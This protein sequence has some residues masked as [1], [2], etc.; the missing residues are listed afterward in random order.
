MKSNDLN[1]WVALYRIE[2]SETGQTLDLIAS[3]DDQGPGDFNSKLT[4][5]LTSDG[6][7][8]VMATSK[9]SGE[10]GRYT[11]QTAAALQT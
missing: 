10:T 11:L 4:A 9:D 8:I 6:Q 1:P 2:E 3:N 7:Y 5:Q